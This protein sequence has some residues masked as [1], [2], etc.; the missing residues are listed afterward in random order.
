MQRNIFEAFTNISNDENEG[1]SDQYSESS[2]SDPDFVPNDESDNT[3]T[4]LDEE[5]KLTVNQT[6]V[7]PM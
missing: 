6:A 2:E 3:S 4:E 7:K 5:M 1:A